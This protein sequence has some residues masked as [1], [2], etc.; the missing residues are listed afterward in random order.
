[1]TMNAHD[2]FE[3]SLKKALEPYE[4]PYNSADWAQLEARMEKAQPAPWRSSLGLYAL[5]LGGTVAL[6]TTIYLLSATPSTEGVAAQNLPGH[7]AQSTLTNVI[8]VPEVGAS[9]PLPV[10]NVVGTEQLIEDNGEE[11]VAEQVAGLQASPNA[12]RTT[13][14]SATESTVVNTDGANKEVAIRPSISEGCPGTAVTFAVENMPDEGIYLWNFGDGSF[15][16]QSRPSHVFSKAGTFEVM[17][18]HSSIG[19]GTI[20]NKPAADRIVIHEIPEAS[21][22]FL[23]QEYDHT[24]P[25]VHFENRSQGAASYHWDFGDGHTSDVAHPDHIFKKA[26]DHTVVLTVT[27]TK[28]CTDRSERTIHIDSGYNLLAANTFSPNGDGVDD[29]FIPEALRNLGVRFKL[30]IHDPR[31][32]QLVYETTDPQR[33]WNGRIS[34]KGEWCTTGDYVWMVEMKDGEKLGGTYNG[35]IGLLR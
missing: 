27:N 2:A 16:N 4:V 1:M 26:G 21:F 32:G 13:G 25:S 19:G 29:V 15:S 35:T 18:S 30:S 8:E 20:Q 9:A 6:G 17:L 28:G 33:P 12:P 24:V 23:K 11:P 14:N 10:E 3:R 7:L 34:N 31:T 5:L 22:K